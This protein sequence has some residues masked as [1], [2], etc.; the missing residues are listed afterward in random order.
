[1]AADCLV[2]VVA[3]RLQSSLRSTSKRR[4]SDGVAFGI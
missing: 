2:V 4:A 3:H 1:V